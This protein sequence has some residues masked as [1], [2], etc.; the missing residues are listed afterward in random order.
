M[1]NLPNR[2][3]LAWWQRKYMVNRDLQLRFAW[4]AI[5]IG[6]FSSLASAGVLLWAFWSF[7]IWQGQRFPLP[8][9]ICILAVLIL[10]MIAIYTV[11]VVATQRIA[12]PL[13]NLMRQFSK[14]QAGD[15]STEAR[16]RTND[17]F[18]YVARAFND[19]MT[20][21]KK[22]QADKEAQVTLALKSLNEGNIEQA[23]AEL[24]KLQGDEI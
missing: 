7:N 22:T 18:H 17:E 3:K 1:E 6:A 2:R 13:F 20:S 10:N 9:W 15:M 12:G 21:L 23:K 11:S 14:V 24:Q 16:F 8:V 4:S 5:F 19:M